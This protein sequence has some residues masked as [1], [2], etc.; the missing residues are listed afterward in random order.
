MSSDSPATGSSPFSDDFANEPQPQGPDTP[1]P[2]QPGAAVPGKPRRWRLAF[3]WGLVGGLAAIMAL[4]W[5][6]SGSITATSLLQISAREQQ[7]VPDPGRSEAAS[8]FEIYKGTQQQWITSDVV[9]TSA[10]RKPDVAAAPVL[11][12]EDD[13]IRWLAR[14][15]RVE[16]PLNTE[17]MR[18]SLTCPSG[19]DAVKLVD[20]IVDAYM[21]EAVDRER[22]AKR[23]RLAELDKLYTEKEAEL[24]A[25]RTELRKL[26]ELL[27]S[28]DTAALA[29]KQ[30]MA[31]QEYAEARGEL[32]RLRV[33]RRRAEDDL[34]IK[35]A[36]LAALKRAPQPAP[37]SEA[38]AVSD[39]TL[40]KLMEQIREL[41]NH[42]AEI[43]ARAKEKV[44]AD[45][46]T[47]NLQTRNDLAK[48]IA[49]RQ[50]EPAKK[51]GQQSN[52]ADLDRQIAE[53]KMRVEILKDQEKLA[54]KDVVDQR[55]KAE[56]YSSS[57]DVEM[58]R[59]EVQYLEKQ[60]APIADERERLKVELRSTPR[61]TVFQRATCPKPGPLFILPLKP[62]IQSWLL[63]AL[64]ILAAVLIPAGIVLCSSAG[65]RML[66][67]LAVLIL[68]AI[69][70]AI[71]G[72][73]PLIAFSILAGLG[74]LWALCDIVFLGVPRQ[75]RR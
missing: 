32:S 42:L 56:Q 69:A 29:Q 25:R 3:D 43:R 36:W 38:G 17:I 5:L 12:K 9:F 53:L 45:A 35:A 27:G 19:D 8:T 49:E 61:I 24:R 40:A 68:A 22:N 10:L 20:A 67:T 26:A 51:N 41:D 73:D 72:L 23:A 74:I 48:Q 54:A 2:R 65:D 28:G 64:A 71:A 6:K 7:L 55:K 47:E 15:V 62:E 52:M 1:I 4:G 63:L 58:M 37:E 75:K 13:P 66:L 70:V 21:N 50:K 60:L 34:R 14:N 57:I 11:Q 46:I 30:H 18:V 16:L 44:I 33:E 59:S 39:P 31:L